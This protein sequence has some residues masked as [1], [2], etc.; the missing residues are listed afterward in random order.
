LKTRDLE[1]ILV[2]ATENVREKV[3]ARA[4]RGGRGMTVGLGAAGDRTII[5]DKEAEDEL[6]GALRPYGVKVLSEEAGMTGDPKSDTL[7]V[8]DPLDGSSNFERGVPFYCT[9]VAIAEGKRLEDV[10]LGVIRDLVR[11][12]VYVANRGEGARRNGK[13]IGTSSVART[14]D[15]IVGIDISRSSPMLVNR[16]ARLAS[17]VKRQIH[18]GANALEI[19]YVADGRIDA[20]VDVRGKMRI[21]DFA[22]AYLIAKEAGAEFTDERG[23]RLEPHFDLDHRFSFV[24]SANKL[25]HS[26]ILELCEEKDERVKRH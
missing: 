16:L 8:I 26:G 9:S 21:T 14:A 13:R 24:A 22:A 15:A 7:A 6:L 11:G 25:L 5:A 1:R 12:D 2:E 23:S 17:G 3:A 10:T 19:C 20:F 18:Y 4:A